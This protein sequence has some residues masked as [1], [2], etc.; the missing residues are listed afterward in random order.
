M[1]SERESRE[2]L[3]HVLLLLLLLLLLILLL[4]PLLPSCMQV[5]SS[6]RDAVAANQRM[7]SPGANFL[8]LNGMLVEIRNFEFYSEITYTARPLPA[9]PLPLCTAH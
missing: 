3:L 7:L 6:L 4:P 8:F 1:M 2:L 5:P 9:D